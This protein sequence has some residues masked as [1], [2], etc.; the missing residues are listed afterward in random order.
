MFYRLDGW[1]VLPGFIQGF[2][3]GANHTVY[4]LS[5]PKRL[6][7]F[8]SQHTTRQLAKALV[9]FIDEH[10]DQV[11]PRDILLGALQEAHAA[12][13]FGNIKMQD[14]TPDCPK[15]W[16][17]MPPGGCTLRPDTK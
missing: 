4:V 7:I 15:D 3:L 13:L 10:P 8:T 2:E 12:A 5:E 1:S 14:L 11:D 9:T 17:D 6:E 16:K